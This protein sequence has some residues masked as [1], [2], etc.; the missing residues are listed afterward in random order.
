MKLF[1]SVD[2]EG[3]T[4]IVHGEQL[5]PEGRDYNIGR[6]LYMND[7]QAAIDGAFDSGVQEVLVNDAHGTMRNILIEEMDERVKIIAGP[8]S[9]K[10]LV[11]TDGIDSTFDGAF[12]LGYHARAGNTD[13]LLSHTWVPVIRELR[14]NGIIMGE[15]SI[16]AAILGSYGVPVLLVTGDDALTREVAECLPWAHTVSVKKAIGRTAAICLPPKATRKLIKQAAVTSFENRKKAQPYIIEP[17]FI[18]EADFINHLTA[19][20]ASIAKDLELVDLTT[21]CLKG[22]NLPEIVDRFWRGLEI[23]FSQP[24]DFLK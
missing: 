5:G 7:L 9:S 20:R 22:D 21:V 10:K 19:K 16:N 23:V 8:A 24:M 17:P 13:G 18:F 11:Q 14:V 6:R 1:I 2:M 4:G 15:S 12:F 3:I